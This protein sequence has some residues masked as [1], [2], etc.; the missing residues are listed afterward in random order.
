MMHRAS[1][2]SPSSCMA[3]TPEERMSSRK[4][5]RSSRVVLLVTSGCLCYNCAVLFA[6]SN[7]WGF[8]KIGR[9]QAQGEQ[10]VNTVY[11]IV[12][13]T[14]AASDV[15]LIF[16]IYFKECTHADSEGRSIIGILKMFIAW[17]AVTIFLC[18]IAACIQVYYRYSAVS[19]CY[20]PSLCAI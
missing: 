16:S 6:V 11:N 10:A 17:N 15:I 3:V 9:H 14:N 12:V 13:F 1:I 19:T 18:W 2:G 20:P 5:G 8:D 7:D 4:V